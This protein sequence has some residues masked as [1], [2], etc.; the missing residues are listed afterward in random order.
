LKGSLWYNK[1]G[2]K[3]I[4]VSFTGRY[5]EIVRGRFILNSLSY[6]RLFGRKS[7]R[8]VRYLKDALTIH[9]ISKI[10]ILIVVGI[11]EVVVI[12]MSIGRLKFECN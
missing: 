3:S 6:E 7:H 2:I 9:I 8:V 12:D 11:R 10:V 1:F 5:E 4:L